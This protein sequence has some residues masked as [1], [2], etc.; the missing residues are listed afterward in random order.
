MKLQFVYGVLPAYVFYTDHIADVN[1]G[2]ANG[3]VVR[4]RPHCRADEGLLK[5]ELTH[6]RQWYRTL[7]LHS[8][9]YLISPKY[10][11]SAEVEAYREQALYAADRLDAV[12]RFAGAIATKYDLDITL[13]QAIALLGGA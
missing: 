4:I 13:A 3:F 2:C 6:V 8:L 10:R 7:G 1:A 11:L 9:L 12:N 5:H